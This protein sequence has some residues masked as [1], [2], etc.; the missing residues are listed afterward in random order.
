MKEQMQGQGVETQINMLRDK[1]A[2]IQTEI[3]DLVEDLATLVGKEKAA[4]EDIQ[5]LTAE[6][7]KAQS[8]NSGI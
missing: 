2:R 7:Q 4:T 8:Q 5:N 3:K 1:Q 6:L